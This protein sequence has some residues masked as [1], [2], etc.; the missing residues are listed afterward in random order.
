MFPGMRKRT[1]RRGFPI[2]PDG[3][4]WAN[5]FFYGGRGNVQTLSV[6]YR[7][8]VDFSRF[9]NKLARFRRA[10]RRKKGGSR[11]NSNGSSKVVLTPTQVAAAEHTVAG[12]LKRL[13]GKTAAPLAFARILEGGVRELFGRVLSL[14]AWRGG[15]DARLTAHADRLDALEAA[16]AKS[17]TGV[18]WAGAYESGRKY[19]GGE[20]TQRNGLWLCLAEETTAAPGSSTDWRLIVHRKLVPRDEDQ[21]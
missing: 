11:M 2:R 19:F 6:S 21:R 4:A 16:N 7:S 20:L 5:E 8:E 13:P 1:K 10:N 18:R 15:M 3:V 17:V 12:W 14:E 9:Q